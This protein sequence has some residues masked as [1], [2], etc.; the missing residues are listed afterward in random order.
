MKN[1]DK[2]QQFLNGGEFPSNEKFDQKKEKEFLNVYKDLIRRSNNEPIPDFD[3]F[4]KVKSQKRVFQIKK[5]IPYAAALILLLSIPALIHFINKK[6][7]NQKYTE[8]QIMEAQ[9]NTKMALTYFSQ[10]WNN[11]LS[12]FNDVNF[13][14][15]L[16]EELKNLKEIKIEFNNPIKNLKF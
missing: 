11:S 10:E 3:T 5:L 1:N 6:P 14:K 12:N 7:T 9:K 4:E 8:V 16:Q 13:N 15:Q 2:F